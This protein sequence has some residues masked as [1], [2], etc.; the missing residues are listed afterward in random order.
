MVHITFDRV[1]IRRRY[2]NCLWT[3]TADDIRFLLC[4]S[5]KQH[6]CYTRKNVTWNQW[7]ARKRAKGKRLMPHS[8]HLQF[9]C[10]RTCNSRARHSAETDAHLQ[11]DPFVLNICSLTFT[12]PDNP[13]QQFPNRRRAEALTESTGQQRCLKRKKKNLMQMTQ[14]LTRPCGIGRFPW[15]ALVNGP[16]IMSTLGWLPLYVCL[17]LGDVLYF[18]D[19]LFSNWILRMN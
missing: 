7:L 6:T 4:W 15:E 11:L 17:L 16:R 3:W 13:I 1:L 8:F 10:W 19:K 9:Q 14:E 18:K 12:S 5:T 2:T